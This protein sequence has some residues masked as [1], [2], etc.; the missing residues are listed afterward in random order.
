MKILVKREDGNNQAP[1]AIVD[2]LC[3]TQNVCTERGKTF[4]YENGFD[5]MC[6]EIDIPY[7]QAI[8]CGDIIKIM[9]ASLG[10]E[11]FARVS[12]WSLHVDWN[13]GLNV[14]QTIKCEQSL[15]E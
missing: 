14:T 9:D 4:L 12:G 2:E 1:D 10:K 8:S 7:R 6:F 11:F 15:E 13:E 5:K 3:C